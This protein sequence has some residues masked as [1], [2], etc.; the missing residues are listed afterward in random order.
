MHLYLVI[1][2]LFHHGGSIP[3]GQLLH[4]AIWRKPED[5]IV[6]LEYISSKDAP[7]NASMYHDKSEIYLMRVPFDSGTPFHEAAPL[8]DP[9][10]LQVL[11]SDGA[12]PDVK[13]SKDLF[14][15]QSAEA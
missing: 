10:I 8:G 7:V 15:F 4:T 9:D 3:Y 1:E 5:Q 14:S 11:I 6:V 2:F 13:D 12:R